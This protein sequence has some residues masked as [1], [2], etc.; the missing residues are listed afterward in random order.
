MTSPLIKSHPHKGSGNKGN[1]LVL[2]NPQ[3]TLKISLKN[4][5][6][7]QDLVFLVENI[8]Y[9]LE[10]LLSDKLLFKL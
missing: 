6:Y 4:Y 2:R 1:P 3:V 7:I 5:N 9:I 10:I 8:L